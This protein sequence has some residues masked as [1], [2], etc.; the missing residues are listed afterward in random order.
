MF[1]HR[2]YLMDVLWKHIE[3]W[4]L[5]YLPSMQQAE[6]STPDSTVYMS[7][8]ARDFVDQLRSAVADGRR[9]VVPYDE[10][11]LEN[12]DADSQ[13]PP[14]G[15]GSPHGC[16]EDQ[17]ETPPTPVARRR[18]LHRVAAVDDFTAADTIG[19]LDDAAARAVVRTASS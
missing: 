17:T 4:I 8:E 2:Q 10:E 15:R 3:D 5:P 18:Q 1:Y 13:V 16:L 14:G 11:W 9:T 12:N 7:D 6:S 19:P